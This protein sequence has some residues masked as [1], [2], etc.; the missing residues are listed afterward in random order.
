M[1]IHR[2]QE[3]RLPSWLWFFLILPMGLIV[4]LLYRRREQLVRRLPS[5]LQQRLEQPLV[6]PRY[7]EPDSIPLEI[8]QRD[9][10]Y[11]EAE[12]VEDEPEAE[13]PVDDEDVAAAKLNRSAA[14]ENISTESDGASFV[15]D[16]PFSEA[17][18][19]STTAAQGFTESDQAASVAD[20][21]AA[22]TQPVSTQPP[23]GEP[24][25]LKVIEGIGPSIAGLLASRGILTFRQLADTPTDQ[26][27]TILTEAG[28]NRL[29]NPET[30]SEQAS[31][32]A[33][34]KWDELTRLQSTLKA[35]RRPKQE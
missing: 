19:A 28:L 6:Q 11:S 26:I 2:E 8:H 29:A 33:D 13:G 3:T 20:Q 18:P 22:V 32:A 35:G 15:A 10:S 14:K 21:A 17:E 27:T 24:D 1:K 12:Y 7:T 5:R 16:R 23:A 4:L 9:V 31:L 25:D 34:G 30:W